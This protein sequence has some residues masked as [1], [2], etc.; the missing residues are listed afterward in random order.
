MR[1]GGFPRLSAHCA[2]AF[3]KIDMET[4]KEIR[5]GKFLSPHDPAKPPVANF[6]SAKTFGIHHGNKF[7]LSFTTV[8]F[9]NMLQKEF[10]SQA[11][12]LVSLETINQPSDV[13]EEIFFARLR[14]DNQELGRNNEAVTDWKLAAAC[15]NLKPALVKT[16]FD[17]GQGFSTVTDLVH[18]A[19]NE[20]QEQEISNYLKDDCKNW[21]TGCFE[22]ANEVNFHSILKKKLNFSQA[23]IDILN[24]S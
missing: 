17:N 11:I 19:F 13:I 21:L 3:H 10:F 22:S 14:Q 9:E 20:F 5:L 15:V 24:Y 4:I 12:A 16:N 7:N 1:G 18:A 2:V 23:Q 8:L 6:D